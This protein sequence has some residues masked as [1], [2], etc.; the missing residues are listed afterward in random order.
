MEYWLLGTVG[1]GTPSTYPPTNKYHPLCVPLPREYCQL[2][3]AHH[4]KASKGARVHIEVVHIPPLLI[5]TPTCSP[6]S[7]PPPAPLH[8]NILNDAEE[9]GAARDHRYIV[10]VYDG[11]GGCGGLHTEGVGVGVHPTWGDGAH[12]TTTGKRCVLIPHHIGEAGRTVEVPLGHKPHLLLLERGV[13][14]YC[15]S[16][17]GGCGHCGPVTAPIGGVL[18]HPIAVVGPHNG[19][20]EGLEDNDAHIWVTL[21]GHQEQRDAVPQG[22]GGPL[23]DGIH[24]WDHRGVDDGGVVHWHYH[25]PHGTSGRAEGTVRVWG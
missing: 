6:P 2:P 16:G 1:A 17:D 22:E 25:Q 23:V 19:Y 5:R 9:L 7:G 21:E 18:P 24:G 15:G 10:D 8:W 3:Y 14:E 20:T 4:S 11:D 12:H 13:G